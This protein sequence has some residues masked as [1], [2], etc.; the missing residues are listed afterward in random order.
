MAYRADARLRE[1]RWV[2]IDATLV[3]AE[4]RREADL[5]TGCSVEHDH[6]DLRFGGVGEAD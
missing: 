6:V 3:R 5:R 1:E 4:Q 2:C